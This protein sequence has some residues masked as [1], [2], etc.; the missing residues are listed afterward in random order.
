MSGGEVDV[1]AR[2]KSTWHDAGTA[3]NIPDGHPRPQATR[4]AW[5]VI[6]PTLDRPTVMTAV[7]LAVRATAT[8]ALLVPALGAAQAPAG[9][10]ITQDVYD[11]WRSIQ[12][13]TLSRDGRWV[14]YSLVP[15]VGDGELVVRATRGSR[16]YRASRGFIGRPQLE[17]NADS[18]VTYPAARFSPDDR[19]VVF[20]AQPPRAEVEQARREKRKPAARPKASLGIL[21]V[22]SGRVVTIPR[23]KSFRLPKERGRHLAYLLEADSASTDSAATPAPGA[24]AAAPGGTPRPIGDSA[25]AKDR[26]REYGT[27]LVVRDLGT[28]TELRASDV[29]SYVLEDSGRVLVY[30]VSSRDESRNGVYAITLDDGRTRTVL[31][32]PGKYDQ[33]AFDRAGRQLA[34]VSDRGSPDR[35][36]PRFALFHAAAPF[37]SARRIVGSEAAGA[38]MRI[39]DRSRVS[40]TRDGSGVLFG[41]ARVAP[42]SIPADSLAD[43][44]VLDLWSWRDTRLQPQQRVEAKRDRERADLAIWRDG[45]V[46]RL[47]TD[48]LRDATVAP[49]GSVALLESELPYAHSAMWGEGGADLWLV[50]TRSGERRLVA[51]RV[52]FGGRLSPDARW[53]IWFD[54]E[55]WLAHEVATGRSADLTGA[56]HGVRFDQETWDTPSTPA[57]WGVAG[58]TPGDSLVLL[59]DRHDVWALDPSGRRA[60]RNVTDSAGRRA[61]V[62]LRLVELDPE[63]RF[64]DPSQPLLL[65]AFDERTKASGFWRDRLG[66]DREPERIVMADRRFG[67]PMKARSADVFLVT[68]STYRQFPDLWTG[69]RLDALARISDANPQQR[70]YRWGSVEMVKWL[71]VDGDTIPGLLYKPDGFDPSRRYPMVV[72]FYE[73]LSDNLHRYHPPAGRN[74]V[75]PTVYNS[76]GYLVFFPDIHYTTG[77]PGPSAVKSIVPGV[78]SLIA[79]GFVD[80]AAIGIAGQSWGGY[81][82][83]YIITQTKLFA[84]AVPNATVANMTSAYGGIRWASGRS[85]SFQYEHTQSRIGGSLWEYPERYIENS[86]LFFA[87]RVETPVL[88]MHNDADGAV[89]WYQGIELYIALKRLGKEVYLVNYNDEGHNPTKRA[90]QLDIDRRM[91]QFFAHHL[92]GAPAPAWMEHGIPFL[93]KGRDQLPAVVEPAPVAG[94]GASGE[95]TAAGEPAA[96]PPR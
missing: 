45:R 35:D 16:E 74:V 92:R 87:D 71:G 52:E 34:F 83:A 54:D 23:V 63:A 24:A 2:R 19:F 65:E 61:S 33:L 20:I 29:T 46:V 91:Q 18:S 78:Q 15:Q 37:D 42:D 55:R 95:R 10:P 60:P 31:A 47:E 72:Y 67:E 80:P 68:Q 81:Q 22:E 39:S 70:E 1:R 43:K 44:A 96:A 73:Q 9:R 94:A 57:P 49:D 17:P 26:K 7:R 84:A 32:G 75:N 93:Q 76:L 25:S 50:D 6:P 38:E 8:L 69:T 12:G 21:S 51:E 30:A 89:P 79:R 56:L 41:L 59:Y 48:T 5:R 66:V 85:R 58:W 86:P 40:F 53:V 3:G 82:T 4:I 11:G 28:G 14:A 64:V 62:V 27:T 88:M 13:E 77:Q 36:H 90:N